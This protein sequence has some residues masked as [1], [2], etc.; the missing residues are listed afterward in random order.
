M[1]SDTNITSKF[2]ER[3]TSE[4][5]AIEGDSDYQDMECCNES[6]EK[7]YID[8]HEYNGQVII[9]QTII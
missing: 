9:F 1:L 6:I 7:G 5:K 8:F 2:F 3:A 4:L